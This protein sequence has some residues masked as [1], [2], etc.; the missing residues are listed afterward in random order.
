[1]KD[2]ILEAMYHLVAKQGY[3]KTSLNQVAQ[4]VSIQ[5]PSLY[6]HYKSKEDI[7]LAV[8]ER[9]YNQL[10]TVNEAQLE[11]L[12]TPEAYRHYVRSYGLGLLTDFQDNRELRL[13][14]DEINIQEQ[15]NPVIAQRM[16]DYDSH[17]LKTMGVLLEKGVSVGAF[18]SSFSLQAEVQTML[19]LLVGLSEVQLFH[20]DVNC[21][22]VWEHY[23][24]RLFS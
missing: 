16:R 23:V 15:R 20:M 8:I 11:C 3:E 7:F 21:I 13:F 6:H 1:M 9:Y 19:V 24:E 10:F 22:L 5:K 14:C 12:T 4:A 2:K 17:T 18:P